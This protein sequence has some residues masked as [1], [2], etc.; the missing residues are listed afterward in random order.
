M[1]ESRAEPGQSS[2]EAA[3]DLGE[4][5]FPSEKWTPNS[6]VTEKKRALK[7]FSW[8]M[9]VLEISAIGEQLKSTYTSSSSTDA[10]LAQLSHPQSREIY[11]LHRFR[12]D[13]MRKLSTKQDVSPDD[14]H[15]AFNNVQHTFPTGALDFLLHRIG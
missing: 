10:L 11:G 12:E 4:F 1:L 9:E 15:S 14:C 13:S 7:P 8:E 5:P 6:G 2:L 3:F